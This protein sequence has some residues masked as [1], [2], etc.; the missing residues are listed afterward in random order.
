MAE[1]VSPGYQA[2]LDNLAETLY[3]PFRASV[4]PTVP[5]PTE[6]PLE[7]PSEAPGPL[8]VPDIAGRDL[9]QR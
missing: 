8:V 9:S 4:E 7:T 5:A 2:R 3:E 1:F 6:E